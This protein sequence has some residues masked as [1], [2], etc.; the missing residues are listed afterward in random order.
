MEKKKKL[1]I[2][3]RYITVNLT[4]CIIILAV[5]VLFCIYLSLDNFFRGDYLVAKYA[6]FCAVMTAFAVVN[7]CI[8]KFGKKKRPWL[9]HLAINVQCIVYWITF[10]FFLYTGGTEGSSIFLFFVGVPIVFFFFNLFYGLYFNLVFLLIMVVYIASPYRELGYQFPEVYY[11]RLPM[12]FL[13]NVVM[14]SIAQYEIVKARIRQDVALEQ[15]RH[16]NEA[17]TDFLANT[18]HEIRT[19]IN[20]VLGMNEMIL[21]ETAKA[22]AMEEPDINK[23]REAF[24]RIRSYSGNVDSAGN[25]LLAIINDIL[26]FTKIEEGKM[27]IVPVEYQLSSVLNDV[28]NM[29]YFKAGEKKL[30]FTTDVDENLPD[31]L[32]GD[33]VR[34][35]QVITNILNNAV[36]YTDEGSVSLKISGTRPDCTE[37]GKPILNLVVEVKDTGIGISRENL[38]KLF[39]K[40][41]RLDLVRN[42]TKEGTGLGLAITKMLLDMMHGRIDVESEYGKGS[43]FTVT[44]PQGIVSDEPIGNF[45]EKFEKSIGE[46]EDYH[47]SFIAP[48]AKILVVDDTRMNLIVA[49]EILKDTK[50]YIDTAISGSDAVKMTLKTRYDV[51]LM[52]QRMPEMDGEETLHEIRSFPG[53]PNRQ[54]PVICLT[55]D[56]VVGAKER[57]ISKGFDD[58]LSKPIEGRVLE[59]MLRKYISPDKI[60]IVGSME[61]TPDVRSAPEGNKA[62]GSRGLEYLSKCGIDIG[63]GISN[64][65][66]EEEFYRSI[67][68]EYLNSSYEKKKKLED[69][70]KAGDMEGY[71]IQVHSLKST[72]ATIGASALSEKALELEHLAKEGKLGEVRLKHDPMFAEY[73]WVLNA[74]AKVVTEEDAM[75]DPDPDGDSI[76][77]FEPQ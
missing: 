47:E 52:D 56:A 40:F 63:K 8:C 43:T 27:D 74:L 72:S 14:C 31:N 17:K 21:R 58:Y 5:L 69:F 71:G 10:T 46:K 54:T 32:F 62:G 1:H 28:S 55:A 34:V 73:S 61:K 67:L 2:D 48:S 37:N 4:L 3:Q 23:Y 29:I 12:M 75:E 6:L 65:G 30:S 57:Y 25:N 39:V 15:A 7:F 36:K 35:R 22:E 53:S 33:V 76:L 18:S 51:I 49:T 59:N 42:S 41:E 20:A 68:L 16:A 9:M 19:P 44:V 70:L 64:C 66:G 24:G 26:D 11:Q 77:E 50:M 13:A 45:K 38:G 60:Q